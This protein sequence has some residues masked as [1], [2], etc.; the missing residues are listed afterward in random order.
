MKKVI[1]SV[2]LL[3]LLGWSFQSCK[4]KDPEP[5][6]PPA[7]DGKPKIEN[8]AVSP[9]SVKYGDVVTLTGKFTD[10]TGLSS[11]TVTMS[12]AQGELYTETKMLTGKSFDLNAPLVLPL[13]K[14]AKAGDVKVSI[15]LKNSGNQSVSEDK[16]L[17][18]VAVPTFEKL[19]LI[20]GSKTLEMEKEEDVYVVEDLFAANAVGKIYTKA[21]KSGLFWGWANNAVASLVDG[22]IAIGIT[23]EANLKVTFNPVTFDLQVT[24]S[25]ET[26]EPIEET[27]YIYGKIGGNWNNRNFDKQVSA[28]KMTGFA[29]ASG[30]KYWTF[31]PPGLGAGEIGKDDPDFDWYGGIFPGEFRFKKADVEEYVLFDGG[32]IVKGNTNDLTKSF[33]T[34][35][36]GNITIKLFYDGTA[37]TKVSLEAENKMLEFVNGDILVGG[38]STSVARNFAGTPLPVKEGTMYVFEAVVDLKKDQSITATG[39][40]LSVPKADPDV[41]TGQ[42]NSTW[43]MIGTPGPWRITIDPFAN[44]IQACKETEYP[45]VIFMD[46]WGWSKSKGDVSKE[47]YHDYILTLQRVGE[48]SVYEATFWNNGWGNDVKFFAAPRAAENHGKKS[49]SFKHFTG[50]T[51]GGDGYGVKVL[52]GGSC[53]EAIVKVQVDLKD[54]FDF[55][56]DTPDGSFFTLVP[57]GTD[58]FTATFTVQ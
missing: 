50:V 53:P 52:A 45:D 48:T 49:I 34:T 9:A 36:D 39:V 29:T 4:D 37:Y 42:G 41:F 8:L 30:K 23:K 46:G 15:S 21:D 24:E 20:V 14:N 18:G 33:V 26:W 28:N 40:N 3:T 17:A 19:F 55:D 58:K 27:F 51:D 16:T 38:I 44:S 6:K 1:S 57:K 47:W 54:G 56:E 22:D 35:S 43:K 13:P 12:N 31:S 32:N 11:Y 7:G 2:L 5:P 10:A 25:E